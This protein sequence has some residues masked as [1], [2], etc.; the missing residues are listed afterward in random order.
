M[1]FSPYITLATE[2]DNALARD[3]CRNALGILNTTY[4]GYSWKVFVK[5]GVC[6]VRLLDKRLGNA[7]WGMNL[8]LR[9]V[10]HDAE[11][12]KRKVKYVAGEFL[13]RSGIS[14]RGNL[15]ELIVRVEGLPK[16]HQPKPIA[17]PSVSLFEG[18][19]ILRAA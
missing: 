13:E 2:W 8:K 10:D 11:F 14:R 18:T 12:F 17:P 9:A 7:P 19:Q 6:F 3:V 15:D 16:R 5:Q 1:I 4:P